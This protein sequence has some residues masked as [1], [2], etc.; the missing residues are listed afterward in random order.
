MN[1]PVLREHPKSPGK[2][3]LRAEGP[4]NLHAILT[5]TEILLEEPQEGTWPRGGNTGVYKRKNIEATGIDERKIAAEILRKKPLEGP[6]PH[7][8][9]E[10]GIKERVDRSINLEIDNSAA[11]I[12][13]R[14]AQERPGP[15]S[16][17][18]REEVEGDSRNGASAVSNKGE[19]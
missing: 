18:C 9:I 11:E 2:L 12:L 6:R 14:D 3:N 19:K 10:I 16:G 1:G 8:R 4:E 5:A 7:C 15:Q 13:L 17:S